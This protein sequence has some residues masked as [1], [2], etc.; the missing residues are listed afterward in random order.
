MR[1]MRAEL[2]P[3]SSEAVARIY[4]ALHDLKDTALHNT[5]LDL[6]W[7]RHATPGGD[8]P[9]REEN[10]GDPNA[11][12]ETGSLGTHVLVGFCSEAS[13]RLERPRRE[14]PDHRVSRHLE[15]SYDT[16]SGP[17]V[18]SGWQC[19]CGRRSDHPCRDQRLT[20]AWRQARPTA[21]VWPI[22]MRDIPGAGHGGHQSKQIPH[23]QVCKYALHAEDPLHAPNAIGMQCLCSGYLGPYNHDAEG[24]KLLPLY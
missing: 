3:L 14:D 16:A 20:L 8:W 12:P 4:D 10:I 24:D 22:V 23:F 5:C 9:T 11:Q 17:R 15:W 13:A 19:T 2:E 21:R 1:D 18:F 6:L 7:D